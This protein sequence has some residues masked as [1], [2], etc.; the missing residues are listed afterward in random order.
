LINIYYPYQDG[1]CSCLLSLDT[2]N[3]SSHRYKY[4][5]TLAVSPGESALSLGMRTFAEP[6]VEDMGN[7]KLATGQVTEKDGK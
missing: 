1:D 6:R 2:R 5:G 7:I 3:P 4:I